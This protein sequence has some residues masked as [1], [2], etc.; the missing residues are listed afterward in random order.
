MKSNGVSIELHSGDLPDDVGFGDCVA[1]DTETMG[2]D[3]RRDRLCLVQTTAG[4]GV[5][6]LVQFPLEPGA[7]G[8]RDRYAA[9]N[10]RAL[11]ADERV[12]KLFHYARF[13][14][15]MLRRHLGVTC[16]PVYCT[17]IASKLVRTYTDRHGLKDL[18]GELLGISLAKEQQSSDWGAPTLTGE[19]LKYAAGDVIHLHRLRDKLNEMLM[20]EGRIELAEACFRFLPER[21]RLDLEGWESEDIFAH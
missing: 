7:T 15:A 13:D 11:L 17:K 19:Q 4:D 6:H 12:T 2:L 14:V 18:C 1:M 10:L 5:C 20:R 8:G 3:L 9:P 21:V 16:R